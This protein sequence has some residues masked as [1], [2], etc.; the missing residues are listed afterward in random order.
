MFKIDSDCQNGFLQDVTVQPKEVLQTTS[1]MF[2]LF[3]VP[4]YT[5][6]SLDLQF[7]SETWVKSPCTL[8]D[9]KK[10]FNFYQCHFHPGGLI[11]RYVG[12]CTEVAQ[13]TE[14]MMDNCLFWEVHW[15]D[16]GHVLPVKV[17]FAQN[18]SS[19]LH[20]KNLSDHSGALT[21]TLI[22]L[23]SPCH[24]ASRYNSAI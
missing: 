21:W 8:T 1:E 5:N 23:R 6:M 4:H 17:I 18:G 3:K 14:H 12:F 13:T 9:P 11:S 15:Q 19:K 7:S 22:G 2:V 24:P 16:S 10:E 20:S